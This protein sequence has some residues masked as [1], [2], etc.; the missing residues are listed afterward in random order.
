M[1]PGKKCE[2]VNWVFGCIFQCVLILIGIW[3]YFD[4]CDWYLVR[5]DI[6]ASSVVRDYNLGNLFKKPYWYLNYGHFGE[7]PLLN[8]QFG[9]TWAEVVINWLDIIHQQLL[10][11]LVK[12]PDFPN[13][14][15][16]KPNTLVIFHGTGY[17][18]N[19][20]KQIQV[21]DTNSQ[22]KSDAFCFVK[23][24]W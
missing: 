4:C 20:L 1:Y 5:K 21:I 13:S 10:F 16:K 6:A 15:A 8:Q 24:R 9:V 11:W 2:V 19:H 18:N 23:C 14:W 22:C 7:I 3:M 12:V 17:I